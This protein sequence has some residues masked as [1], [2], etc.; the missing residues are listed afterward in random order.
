[1]AYSNPN[2]LGLP[3]RDLSGLHTRHGIRIGSTAKQVAGALGPPTITR[4][5][6]TGRFKYGYMRD[7]VHAGTTTCG[8]WTAF[9]FDRSARVIAIEDTSGC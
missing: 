9:V 4:D 6:I 5:R 3:E 2:A 1:M 7:T 8:Q